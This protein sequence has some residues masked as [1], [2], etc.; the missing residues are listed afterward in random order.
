MAMN[1]NSNADGISVIMPTYNQGSF[2]SRALRSLFL[3]SFNRWELII[4][5]D[6]CTDYTV[7]VLTEFLSQDR[8]KYIETEKNMGLGFCLNKGIAA[9]T[10]N[11]IAYLPSDDIIFEN[12]LQHYTI[13]LASMKNV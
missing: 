12:H 5:N 3:Q 10:Y 6:S 8:V 11:L 1:C 13:Q 2:I 4:V 7:Q 9:A